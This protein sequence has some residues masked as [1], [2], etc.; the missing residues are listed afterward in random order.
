MCSNVQSAR[1]ICLKWWVLAA[2]AVFLTQ[3]I[4]RWGRPVHT[5]FVLQ[6]E[7][8]PHQGG[9]SIRR[10][11]DPEET[12]R[13]LE[14]DHDGVM[15]EFETPNGNWKRP[16]RPKRWLV[17]CIDGVP[18]AEMRR[19]WDEGH[20]REFYRPSE[21]ISTF[22]SDTETALTSALNAAPVPGY[23][24]RFFDRARNEL[25]GGAWITLTGKGIPY[26]AKLDY[27]E[28]G[29]FKGL[30][31]ILQRKSYRADLGRL[32]AKFQKSRGELFIAHIA[33]TDA[34]Y[35]IL[36]SEKVR[37]LL[38]E[39][40][41]I[42]QELYLEAGGELGVIVFSDHGNTLTPSHVVPLEM[43]L[44]NRGWV[45]TNRLRGSRDVVIPAYGLI[46]FLAAYCR[47]ESVPQLAEDLATL[48]GADLVVYR[49]SSGNGAWVLSPDGGR[50][51]L[52]WSSG[53][54]RYWYEPKNGDPLKLSPAFARLRSAKQLEED[55]SASDA[56]LFQATADAWYTDSAARIREWTINHVQNRASIAVSLKP[57]YLHGSGVFDRIVNMAGTHGALDAPSSLGLAMATYPLPVV[58]RLG[59]L[60]PRERVQSDGKGPSIQ[61]SAMP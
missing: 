18:L 41:A 4:I 47:D 11:S 51:H 45:L 21:L 14:V 25:R 58:L 10:L 34:L 1:T 57:G 13:A 27:D 19:L 59:E 16:I 54:Q 60:I 2:V 36:S 44:K 56:T 33:S 5:K 3:H 46:G 61:A 38:L 55:G 26:L 22:P 39:F 20:F 50:A 42:I 32:V 53:G 9:W 52:L 24:H 12:W 7:E 40:E 49:D 15:D 37:P 31:F 43:L 29:M 28:P 30:H 17:I 48:E 23:E 35:H 6:G 8:L